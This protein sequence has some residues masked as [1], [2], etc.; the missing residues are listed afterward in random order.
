MNLEDEFNNEIKNKL[1]SRE[2]EYSEAS[3]IKVNALIQEAQ[4]K[5]KRRFFF[6]LLSAGIILIGTIICLQ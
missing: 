1:D 2:F 3:W 5:K 4:K 6:Y